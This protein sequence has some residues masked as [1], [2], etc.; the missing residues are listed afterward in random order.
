MIQYS[1][2]TIAAVAGLVLSSM[3]VA[4]AAEYRP[5]TQGKKLV[6]YGWN[7]PTTAY[8]RANIKEMEKCPLHGTV[9]RVAREPGKMYTESTEENLCWQPFSTER[10]KPEEYQH[11]I[12]DLKATDFT[13]MTHNFVGLTTVPGIDIA[14]DEA[15]SATRHRQSK[16]AAP[17]R[18]GRRARAT[19]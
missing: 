15:W 16:P 19:C 5:S 9:L 14:D 13:T 11:A 8:I 6:T 3:P 10:F 12:D 1:V 7:G 18:P 4:S 17:R 2:A